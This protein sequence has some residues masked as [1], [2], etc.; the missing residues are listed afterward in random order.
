[1]CYDLGVRTGALLVLAVACSST[2]QTL[3]VGGDGGR[4]TGA[5][6]GGLSEAGGTSDSSADAPSGARGGVGGSSGA[7]G[8]G[9]SL[10]P[11][12]SADAS[13]AS[14][15]VGTDVPTDASPDGSADTGTNGATDAAD[16]T[17]DTP[18][19]APDYIESCPGRILLLA[20]IPGE[21]GFAGSDGAVPSVDDDEGSCGGT[22]VADGVFRFTTPIAGTVTAS[23]SALFYI[24]STCGT[25]STEFECSVAGSPIQFSAGSGLSYY[26]WIEGTGSVGVRIDP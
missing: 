18:A 7:I 9:G 3:L 4:E 2:Q 12:A 20:P 13:E 5:G 6:T 24:R 14:A 23:A 17:A 1:M 11:E 26:I 25:P 19:D 15:D 22:G 8:M 10:L 21:D 16:S